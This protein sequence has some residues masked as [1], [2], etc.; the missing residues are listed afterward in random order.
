MPGREIFTSLG[1][2]R[3]VQRPVGNV[4]ASAGAPAALVGLLLGDVH[5]DVLQIGRCTKVYRSGG[6]RGASALANHRGCGLCLPVALLLPPSTLVLWLA[7]SRGFLFL[8]GVILI[9]QAVA[10][11]P[12]K[13][14]RDGRQND[15]NTRA[16]F[17][18]GERC[19]AVLR[20]ISGSE[21]ELMEGQSSVFGVT[22]RMD[23]WKKRASNWTRS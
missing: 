2:R 15:K 17:R 9:P 1:P 23:L 19:L 3:G 6:V 4:G 20:E 7:L 18:T 12:G 11:E 14:D 13:R 10:L 21:R 5:L 8:L 16:T 22:L